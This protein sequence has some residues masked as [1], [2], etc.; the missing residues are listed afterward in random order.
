M[1]KR[2]LFAALGI[3]ISSNAFANEFPAGASTPNKEEVRSYL[4]DKV[5]AVALANGQS[6]RLEFKS[7]GFFFV[8]TSSG[9][10]G[11]GKWSPE[12][13]KICAQ[14]T[15][16]DGSCQDTRMLAGVMHVKRDDGEIIRYVQ[17]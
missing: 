16:R 15:G 3:A 9:F 17:K 2:I 8:N 10:N 5:F 13:G 7:N 1:S 4:A 14:L 11:Q 6:W 12:D